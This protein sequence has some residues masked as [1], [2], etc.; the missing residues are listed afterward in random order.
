MSIIGAF[1]LIGSIYAW[2]LE[3]QTAPPEDD[4]GA[5]EPPA[6]GSGDDGQPVPALEGASD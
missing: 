5:L 3:P 6:L 4:D 2:A 1:W